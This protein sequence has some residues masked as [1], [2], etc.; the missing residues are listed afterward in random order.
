VQIIISL[1][2]EVLKEKSWIGYAVRGKE[3][4]MQVIEGRMKGKKPR[5]RSRIEIINDLIENYYVGMRMKRK[6]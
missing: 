2:E 4:L 6:A 1:S 3:F 5:R